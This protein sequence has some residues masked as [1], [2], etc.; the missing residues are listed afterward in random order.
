M[1]LLTDTHPECQIQILGGS[2]LCSSYFCFSGK[3][4]PDEE[5]QSGFVLNMQKL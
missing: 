5:I 1:V 3:H 2:V 4:G